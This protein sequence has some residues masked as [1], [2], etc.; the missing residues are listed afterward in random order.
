MAQ[1]RRES[2]TEVFQKRLDPPRAPVIAVRFP[3]LSD[4]AKAQPGVATG[5]LP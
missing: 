2:V 1:Q 5:V 3:D 4:A